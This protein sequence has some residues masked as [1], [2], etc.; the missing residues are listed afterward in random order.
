MIFVSRE[1]LESVLARSV[2]L[3]T[4]IARSLYLT[5]S[6]S[7]FQ[8]TCTSEQFKLFIKGFSRAHPL[9]SLVEVGANKEAA[10]YKLRG[11][12]MFFCVVEG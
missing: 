2:S 6:V 10:D 4:M 7:L 8:D 9:F 3:Q 11:K 5:C 12:S 1:R